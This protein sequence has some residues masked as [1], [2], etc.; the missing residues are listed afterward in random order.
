VC[1]FAPPHESAGKMP[2]NESTYIN[3]ANAAFESRKDA[4]GLQIL[5]LFNFLAG[6]GRGGGGQAMSGVG[7]RWGFYLERGVALILGRCL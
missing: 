7:R 5:L 2:A 1:P 6:R 4:D 3:T